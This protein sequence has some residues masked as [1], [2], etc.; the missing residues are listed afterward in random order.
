MSRTAIRF[1]VV[2]WGLAGV[3]SAQSVKYEKYKLPNGMT[4]ILHED[5][6]LPMASVNLWYRVGAKDEPKG[7]SGFAHLFEHLMF[8]GT[9]RAPGSQFDDL[10]EAAGGWSNASTS[11]DRTNYFEL[12]PSSLLPTLLWLEADRLE[13]LGR[14]MT[15]AKLDKQR[16]VVR[17][18]RRQSYENQPYG[19]A[20]LRVFEEMFP[21]GHPYH[22]PVIGTHEDL[23]AATVGD[24]KNFFK[25]Y[26]LPRNASLVVAGDFDS[27]KIKP[28]VG[29]LFGTLPPGREPT[30]RQAAPVK[31]DKVKRVAMKDAVQF[32]KTIMVYHSPKHY[33][34]GDAEM[35]LAAAILTDGI[36]SRLYQALIYKNKL[37]I[38]VSAHQSSMMLGS[39]FRIEATAKPGVSL[40]R[41]EKVI[42]DVV[43]KFIKDGPTE[44]ELARQKAK[45]EYGMVTRLQSIMSKADKL[46]QYEFHF[47]EPNSFQRDLDRYRKATATGVQKVAAK[48]LTPNA[49]LILRVTPLSEAEKDQSRASKE[50]VV[51]AQPPEG[52]KQEVAPRPPSARDKKPLTTEVGAFAAPL[53]KTFALSNGML[54]HH[55]HRPALPLTRMRMLFDGGSEHDGQQKMGLA[56]LTS[57][58]LDEGAG[59]LGAIQ[60]AN[61][62]ETLGARFRP[63]SDREWTAV[64]VEVLTGNFPQ[65]LKLFADAVMRPR[66]D[67]KEWRRVQS[68]RVQRLTA[69]QDRPTAVATLVAA[70]AFFGDAHP[71]GRP[72][73]GTPESVAKLSLDDLKQFHT[74]LYQPTGTSILIAGDLTQAQAKAQLEK[75]FGGWSPAGK[76][77]L[78]PIIPAPGAAGSTV[79]FDSQPTGGL[80]P[81]TYPGVKNKT[82]RTVLIHRPGA[83]QTVIRFIMPGPVYG[84]PSRGKLE[85]LSTILGGSFTSRLNRNLREEH[86]Y[87]YGARS[88]YDFGVSA[89]SLVAS[90]SVRANVTG[91]SLAEFLK[92][93]HAF[94][95]KGVSEEESKKARSTVRL[96]TVQE[97]ED[98]AGLIAQAT[99]QAI[100]G[101]P[102]ASVTRELANMAEVTAEKL[103]ALTRP[104]VLLEQAVLVLVG[105]KASILKQIKGLDLP[106]PVELTVTGDP[107]APTGNRD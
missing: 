61:A 91:A 74:A 16:A 3:A 95:G 65:A 93:F 11:E 39:L 33:A 29:K 35:D 76:T 55:W 87:T 52:K 66:F 42:D 103:N 60:F 56:S 84:H 106:A 36:S 31:L 14:E 43:A 19:M 94:R 62:L 5:D 86:G 80:K 69:R 97:Y 34:R 48:V 81:P 67:E 102:F 45:I 100:N 7:R 64:D 49:R 17:N 88:R 12:G 68:L 37:A 107:V 9:R 15:H 18:E 79:G 46:N 13:D 4:V 82:F 50:A 85:L 71:Y 47:G 28:L 6:S 30:Y 89:G 99:V 26:Y 92:E 63:S 72:I 57:D 22:I 83:V 32:D 10:M 41:I 53:P 25:A 38:D 59:N 58:L 70:R 24:V 27:K 1:G 105:D 96:R 73:A 75:A 21:Q 78:Q 20:E 51:S 44:D 90:S 104:A 23:E 54:V 2:V 77:K 8:M 101:K 40:D 98:L